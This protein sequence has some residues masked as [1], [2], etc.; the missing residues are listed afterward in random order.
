[1]GN[2]IIIILDENACWVFYSVDWMKRNA[3]IVKDNVPSVFTL[4]MHSLDLLF[5]QVTG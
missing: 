4:E 5:S 3:A 1:M 2:I